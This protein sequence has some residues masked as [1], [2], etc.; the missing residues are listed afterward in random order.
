VAERLALRQAIMEFGDADDVE[1]VL[2]SHKIT[3]EKTDTH[4]IQYRQNDPRIG[5]FTGDPDLDG[6]IASLARN[7]G[8]GH[9]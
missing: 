3:M 4:L 8:G 1:R 7:M 5:S 2:T 6:W 9:V